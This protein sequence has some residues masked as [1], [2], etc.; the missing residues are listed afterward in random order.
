MYSTNYN[1]GILKYS[2]IVAQKSNATNEQQQ[3]LA[4]FTLFGTAAQRH[5]GTAESRRSRLSVTILY[6]SF[7]FVQKPLFQIGLEYKRTLSIIVCFLD[8]QDIKTVPVNHN[9]SVKPRF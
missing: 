6:L 2:I 7:C 9:H 1:P 4:L 8:D 3:V 5:S